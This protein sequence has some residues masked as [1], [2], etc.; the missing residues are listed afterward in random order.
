MIYQILFIFALFFI[1]IQISV[2]QSIVQVLCNKHVFEISNVG[3]MFTI[4][5]PS[6]LKGTN[7]SFLNIESCFFIV[8]F[9]ENHNRCCFSGTNLNSCVTL[10]FLH[11]YLRLFCTVFLLSLVP[12]LSLEISDSL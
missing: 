4:V 2:F 9:K 8:V 5:F 1:Y 6:I 10:I 12:T 7:G 11:V 3:E